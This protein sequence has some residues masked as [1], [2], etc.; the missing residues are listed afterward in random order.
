VEIRI[1]A[2]ECVRN[3]AS[4]E[5]EFP[6]ITIVFSYL[7]QFIVSIP[8]R[9]KL[10]RK[11]EY[12]ATYKVFFPFSPAIWA[13]IYMAKAPERLCGADQL[14]DVFRC[15]IRHVVLLATQRNNLLGFSLVVSLNRFDRL[16]QIVLVGDVVAPEYAGCLVPGDL[17]R[18]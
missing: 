9:E 2:I 13:T 18:D 4:H 15:G 6:D 5:D 17:H 11:F 16:A 1:P 7:D 14:A 3:F 10:F 8:E 12:K